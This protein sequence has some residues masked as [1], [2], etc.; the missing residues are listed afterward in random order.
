MAVDGAAPGETRLARRDVLRTAGAVVSAG[1]LAGCSNVL[2]ETGED[3]DGPRVVASFF[4]FYDFARHVA[5]GTDLTVENLVPVGLHGHGWEPDA[6]ITRAIV[7]ADGF[8][9]VGEG[10]QPWA[11]R[12]IEVVERDAPETTLIDARAGID[13]LDITASVEDEA[14]GDGK[15]PHFWLDP[16]RAKQSVETIAEGLADIH[17]AEAETFRENAAAFAADLD[18]IDAAYRSLFDDPPRDVVFLAAHNAFQYVGARYDVEM[19]PLVYTLAADD[20]V[21]PT[22]V[23]RAQSVIADDDIRYIGAAVFESLRPARQLLRETPVEAYFPVTPFAGVREDWVE[24]GWGYREI[25]R[26]VNLPTFEVLVGAAT[27]TAADHT[28]WR[29][30]DPTDV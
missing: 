28:D 25:A 22:D 6:S 26:N 24:R 2:G 16:R 27:P 20:S 21:R 23:T 14:V 10:F 19:H 7:D 13:L 12:A 8:V 3:G 18:A 17:P 1:S 30:F 4:S 5:A 15:D 9:H 29:N 11:D